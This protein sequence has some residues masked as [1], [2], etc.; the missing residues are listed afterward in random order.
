M[1]DLT[2]IIPGGQVP[3]GRV[4]VSGA[5]NSAVLLMDAALL[6]RDPVHL[7]NFPTE[8]VDTRHKG[9]FHEQLGAQVIFDKGRQTLDIHARDLTAEPVADYHCP[10]RTTYLLAAGQLHRHGIARIPYPGG[11]RIGNRKYD[12]H[13]MVWE[14]MGAKVH[15]TAE[16]I[17]ITC[18]Q[19]RGAEIVFPFPT[20]GGTQTALLCASVARGRTIIRNAYIN[21]EVSD[22]INCLT[23]MGAEIVCEGNS[24][25]TVVGKSRLRGTSYR[26]MPDRIEAL[27]RIVYGILSG[28]EI[29]IEPVPFDA[30]EVPLIHLR[31]A[32]IDLFR[33]SRSVYISPSCMNAQQTIQPFEMAT[34][35]YPGVISDMQPFYVLLGLKADGISR[36][37]DYRYPE[38]T[39][40][41]RELEKLCPG[42]IDWDDCGHISVTG[43]AR[44]TGA[45][46]HSTDLRGSMAVLLGGLLAEGTSLVHNVEMALRGYNNLQEK[47]QGLGVTMHL[48]APEELRNAEPV[49]A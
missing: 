27:T 36:I 25:I 13:V 29:L 17:E 48:Y 32:G 6:T 19:L 28:G 15:E 23:A 47:L 37:I 21:P 41:L 39:A 1:T 42:A 4:Q 16:Y 5:K 8:L 3:K 24:R 20:V 38:R 11:C 34:G 12:L 10:V 31:E 26:V 44:F 49:A 22:L 14:R 40:Y 7:D 30:M 2:A 9:R 46:M 33:N 18:P 43:P 35:T 45:A